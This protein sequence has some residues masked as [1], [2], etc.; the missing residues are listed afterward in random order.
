MSIS[1]EDGNTGAL[2]I[3]KMAAENPGSGPSVV[4]AIRDACAVN[5]KY[6]QEFLNTI[7]AFAIDGWG[8]S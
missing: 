1:E 6:N 5:S 3:L 8:K 4:D 2:R 7:A